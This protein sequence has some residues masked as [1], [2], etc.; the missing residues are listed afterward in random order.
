ME[1]TVWLLQKL[2]TITLQMD[3]EDVRSWKTG[4]TNSFSVASSFKCLITCSASQPF[5]PYKMFQRSCSFQ[6]KNSCMGRSLELFEYHNSAAEKES[7]YLHK[8]ALC[9]C[10]PS[11][12]NIFACTAPLSLSLNFEIDSSMLLI[13]H[14]LVRRRW[15]VSFH[16]G[17]V[18]LS[19][20]KGEALEWGSPCGH[21]VQFDEKELYGIPMGTTTSTFGLI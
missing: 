16:L 20:R 5:L 21:L 13:L 7:S 12:S 14:K 4:K 18:V 1:E 9:G 19:P 10:W 17:L 8:Y 15:L 6:S 2:S 3:K 11:R